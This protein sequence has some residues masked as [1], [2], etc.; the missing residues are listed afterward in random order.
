[1][2]ERNVG[3]LERTYQYLHDTDDPYGYHP[4]EYVFKV[5]SHYYKCNG[6]HIPIRIY[7]DDIYLGTRY[8]NGVI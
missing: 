5:Q 8:D 2:G 6:I 4:I 7:Y 3:R 1:M